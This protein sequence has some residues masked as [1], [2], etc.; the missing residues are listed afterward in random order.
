MSRQWKGWLVVGLLLGTMV[1]AIAEELTLTTYYP[2]PRGVYS[3][4]R[5]TDNTYLAIEGGNVGIGTT[6]PG[7]KLEVAGQVKIT[8]GAP[9]TNKALTSDAAGL[10]SWKTLAEMGGLTGSGTTNRLAKWTGATSLG[11]SLLSDNGSSVDVTGN[12][13]SC[14]KRLRWASRS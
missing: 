13:I 4:L 3:E 11:N 5:T 2:S 8:G 12:L 14:S 7:A 1:Y 9:G 6:T 10:A